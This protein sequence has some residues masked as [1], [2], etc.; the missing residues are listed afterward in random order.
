M[1][2]S[3][4]ADGHLHLVKGGVILRLTGSEAYEVLSKLDD[5][6]KE[7]Y[8]AY[9][10]EVR[11]AALRM[12]LA[13]RACSM[14][15]MPE[16]RAHLSYQEA[17]LKR[18]LCPNCG[19][20]GIATEWSDEDFEQFVCQACGVPFYVEKEAL[21]V[22]AGDIVNV[23]QQTSLHQDEPSTAVPLEGSVVGKRA[24]CAKEKGLV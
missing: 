24:D 1:I 22:P 17:V 14:P 7:L 2:I 21:A 11:H 12:E 20:Q 10:A 3:K 6:R 4:T 5:M 15:P 8:A 13:G 16:Q 18:H 23:D 19:K 9:C